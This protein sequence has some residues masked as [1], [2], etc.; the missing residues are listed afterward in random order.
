M[1]LF[2]FH[3]HASLIAR[4]SFPINSVPR[5]VSTAILLHGLWGLRFRTTI[6]KTRSAS[7]ALVTPDCWTPTAFSRAPTVGGFSQAQQAK[8]TPRCLSVRCV[9]SFSLTTHNTTLRSMRS[10][11]SSSIT[12]SP[13]FLVYEIYSHHRGG[14]L[15]DITIQA[16][17]G[18]GEIRTHGT[19]RHACFQDR[20]FRPLSHLSNAAH[21]TLFLHF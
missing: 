7:S 4:R 5:L 2:V 3:T 8:N 13:L 9:L 6:S 18:E 12:S 20:C 11:A 19:L 21:N 15:S 14:K 17:C 1:Y 16:N 10:L